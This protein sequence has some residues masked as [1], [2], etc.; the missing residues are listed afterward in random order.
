MSRSSRQVWMTLLSV[1]LTLEITPLRPDTSMV[2]GDGEAGEASLI[3]IAVGLVNW[4]PGSDSLPADSAA[5]ELRSAS[6]AVYESS[7]SRMRPAQVA[8]HRVTRVAD[9]RPRSIEPGA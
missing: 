2:E 6:E 9:T 4:V 1:T 5:S 8:A 7:P 3:V